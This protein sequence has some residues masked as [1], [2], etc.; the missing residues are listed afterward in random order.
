MS[1]DD[2]L[3]DFGIRR[4]PA[5]PLITGFVALVIQPDTATI[6]A[7]YDLAAAVMPAGAQQVLAPGS[8]PHVTLTQCAVRDLPRRRAAEFVGRLDQELRGR[9]IPLSAVIPFGGGFVFWCVDPACGERATLQRAHEE[10]VTLADG[11]LDPVVNEKVVEGTIQTTNDA[12]V[13]VANARVCGYAFVRDRYLPHI[14]LGFD[15]NLAAADDAGSPIS[16]RS[17]AIGS[18]TGSPGE[19]QRMSPASDGSSRRDHPHA[20]TVDRVALARLGRF[21]RVDAVLSL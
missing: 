18:S 6:R 13:L 16:V 17:M 1:A 5:E 8:L 9:T 3:T 7:A 20:M 19:R 2:T 11:F 4:V 15:P 21:G 12:P 14:T 10:A